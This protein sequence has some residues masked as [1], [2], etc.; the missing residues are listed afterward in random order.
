[1]RRSNV[2]AVAVAVALFFALGA[3]LAHAQRGGRGG[4]QRGGGGAAP[5]DDATILEEFDKM[6]EL[7]WTDEEE[8][9]WKDIDDDA[10]DEK[11][12]FIT[13]FWERRDPTPATEE[14][15]FRQVWMERVAGA[16]QQFQGEGRDGWETDRGKFYLVYGPEVV[17]AQ[18]RKTVSGSANQGVSA[19]QRAGQST[20]IVWTLDPTQNPFLDDKDE[21]TFAQ[22]QRTY[23]RISGGFD[24]NEEAFLAGRAVSG[25]FEARRANPGAAGPVAGG[26]AAG[27]GAATAGG[28]TTPDVVAMQQLMQ[29]GVTAQ[30]LAL[31]QGMGFIPAAG[32]NT[33]AIF[34]FELG[35]EALTFESEGVPGP[36]QMLAFGVL[37]KKD[38]AAPNGEQFLREVKINFSVDPSNGDDQKTTTHS[39]GMTLEPGDYRLAW[40]VMDNASENIATTSYEFT[41]PNYAAAELAI[42]SVIVANGLDQQ[43][44][45]ID[46][47][48]IYE[49][50]RVGNLALKTDLD[51]IFGRN[52]SLLVLYFIQGLQLDPTTQQPTFDVDHR[53]LLAGTEDSIARLP[54]Q[55]LNFG[56]IQQEIPLAQVQQLEAGQ[57]YEIEIH[58]TDQ[59]GG[60]ELTLK[61]PFT[62]RGG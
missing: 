56:A 30:G 45:A 12:A 14:N 4:G 34:N 23:S 10:V 6:V 62:V 54:T 28:G 58:I 47:N 20:N 36:A 15:E 18:E 32:G 48:T 7:I 40:G 59:L 11:Q 41:A 43:T 51:S 42:P 55:T 26:P 13:S 1:M 9:A 25:Y 3:E 29:N 31:R 2:L 52:D 24:Y 35:K 57:D 21:I 38:P 61:V 19:E 39:F 17:T 27:G 8:D 44:D 53:I 60:N 16:A 46:I 5:V 33:F 37:L 49:G 50:S 22:I